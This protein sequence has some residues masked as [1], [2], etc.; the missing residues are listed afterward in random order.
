MRN[1]QV[2]GPEKACWFSDFASNIL[3]E[4]SICVVSSTQR[5]GRAPRLILVLGPKSLT[6][7]HNTYRREL[8]VYYTQF[9]KFQT[10]TSW[11]QVTSNT[12]K[13]NVS[14]RQ[15]VNMNM[16]NLQ[17]S[18][19]MIH[20]EPERNAKKMNVWHI[21]NTTTVTI[22]SNISTE[23][24]EGYSHDSWIQVGIRHT[25]LHTHS[26]NTHNTTDDED[27]DGDN[28]STVPYLRT[29]QS[30]LTQCSENLQSPSTNSSLHICKK[31]ALVQALRLCIGSTAHT[32]SRGIA[33]PF[34]DHS[35]RRGWGVS[36]TPRPLFT[37]RKRPGTRCM[38]GWVGPRTS[39]DRCGKSRPPL[40]FDSRTIQPIASRYTD[41]AT[42]PTLH[43]WL[44]SKVTAFITFGPLQVCHY[45]SLHY[46]IRKQPG[47]FL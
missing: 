36:V 17:E 14:L 22:L 43:I 3:Y 32:G 20:N 18:M 29:L 19:M 24:S 8:I 27:D 46:F 11:T 12:H 13:A 16:L 5:I 15:S 9:Q 34:H 31:C 21:S 10:K 33:L 6:L 30:S 38:G 4:H 1:Y 23:G 47:Q 35:T 2:V 45:N 37:P 41:W 39:L 26:N 7:S 44:Y 42:Q 25:T 40:G 28:N